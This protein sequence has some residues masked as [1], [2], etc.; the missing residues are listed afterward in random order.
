MEQ[1]QLEKFWQAILLEV[2]N[3]LTP[4]LIE[5]WLKPLKP[6]SFSEQILTLSTDNEIIRQ[7]FEQRYKDFA[8]D[9]ARLAAKNF[10]EVQD[11]AMQII[12]EY[13]PPVEMQIEIPKTT[14]QGSLFNRSF[15]AKNDDCKGQDLL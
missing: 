10:P 12:I 15:Y 11:N 13:Q 8:M 6:V 4:Q 9:A 14:G 1:Q 2:E 5:H 7:F 3:F